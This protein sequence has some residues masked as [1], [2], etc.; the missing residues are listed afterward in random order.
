MIQGQEFSFGSI[1]I[2]RDELISMEFEGSTNLYLADRVD[3]PPRI[4]PQSINVDTFRISMRLSQDKYALWRA[5]FQ[6][7]PTGLQ[8]TFD[9]GY[10][11]MTN[12]AAESMSATL[13]KIVWNGTAFEKVWR[14]NVVIIRSS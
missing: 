1:I 3:N 14:C 7:V 11:N 10:I 12:S 13:E 5:Y 6:G 8:Q 2:T 4:I 9:T